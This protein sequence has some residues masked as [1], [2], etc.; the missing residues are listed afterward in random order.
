MFPWMIFPIVPFNNIDYNESPPTLY[1][2]LNSIVNFGKD[3]KTKIVDL[4]KEG[5]TKVFDFSY[6][7]SEKVDKEQ[8]ETMILNKFLMRRIGKETFTA[9]QIS[10]NVK[11]NEIM[12]KYNKLFDSFDDWNILSDGELTERTLNDDKTTTG[13]IQTDINSTNNTNSKLDS[14]MS[15]LPQNEIVDVEN[16]S[17]MTEY[18]LNQG[19]DETINTSNSTNTT[20]MNDTIVTTE[21]I[22][23]TELN[24]IDIFTRFENEVSN[25]MTLI[26]KDLDVLFYQIVD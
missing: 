25:I 17:Y 15:N 9:F 7:L 4:A 10:L 26:Y 20:N 24:K 5:R 3:E 8:F 21:T 23:R 14:R 1:S 11:L 13:T 2:L 19:E 6:P 12:P 18:Q 16:G 22:K